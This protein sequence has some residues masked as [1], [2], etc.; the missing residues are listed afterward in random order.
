MVLHDEATNQPEKR[1]EVSRKPAEGK[2]HPVFEVEDARDPGQFAEGARESMQ[3]PASITVPA[4]S[5]LHLSPLMHSSSLG[6]TDMDISDSDTNLE[7]GKYIVITFKEDCYRFPL[8]L[9]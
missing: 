8:W 7:D 9:W 1:N 3:E 6:S 4:L 5:P 2:G